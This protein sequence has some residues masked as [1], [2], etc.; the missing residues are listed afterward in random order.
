MDN[1]KDMEVVITKTSLVEL[2]DL[3]EAMSKEAE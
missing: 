1:N 3:Q 2:R